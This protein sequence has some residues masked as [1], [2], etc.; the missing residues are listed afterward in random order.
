MKKKFSF[1]ISLILA[2]ALFSTTVFGAIET[3]RVLPNEK[4]LSETI[5]N[6]FLEAK[7]DFAKQKSS[8]ETESELETINSEE[9]KWNKKFQENIKRINDTYTDTEL[10]KI[11][12][13][14]DSQIEAIRN[15]DGSDEMSTQAATTYHGVLSLMSY[16][17][18]ESLDKTYI[19][20]R[21]T[22]TIAGS[23]L[24]AG[25]NVAL[26]T[27]GS[28]ANY[29]HNSSF[30]NATYSSVNGQQVKRITN[31]QITNGSGVA[32]SF[33]SGWIEQVDPIAGTYIEYN[34]TKT[35]AEYS[36]V[37]GGRVSVSG[38]SASYLTTGLSLVF[39]VS[40]SSSGFGISIAPKFGWIKRHD[41]PPQ[42]KHLN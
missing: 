32:F 14:S 39:G 8:V 2:F 23:S 12:N 15:Y 38:I 36:A 31:R 30:L 35:I 19:R 16:S 25:N 24:N 42:T 34:L 10:K 4:I 26:A 21:Y 28:E 22:T 5:T 13:Y 18:V 29:F 11:F 41:A 33:N 37:A 1:A 3:E 17:Y 20:S 7:K 9:A 27:A 40:F 6:E